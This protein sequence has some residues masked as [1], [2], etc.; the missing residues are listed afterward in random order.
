MGIVLGNIILLYPLTTPQP[1]L[2][3]IVLLCGP[4][5]GLLS[6]VKPVMLNSPKAFFIFSGI[7]KSQAQVRFFGGGIILLIVAY[8]VSVYN[9]SFKFK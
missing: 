7:F 5:P 1:Q 9:L 3:L 4:A 8:F 6:K 2:E